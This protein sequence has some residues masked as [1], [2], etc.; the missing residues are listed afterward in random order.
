ML[1]KETLDWAE[2]VGRKYMDT[3]VGEF[4]AMKPGDL[5]PDLVGIASMLPDLIEAYRKL[6][7]K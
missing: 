5:Y 3:T 4:E 1:A 6:H 2:G 7:K